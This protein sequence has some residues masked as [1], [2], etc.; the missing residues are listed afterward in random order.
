MIPRL[1]RR[2][3]GEPRVRPLP[4]VKVGKLADQVIQMARAQ[5]HEAVQ[6]LALE[7][8]DEPLREGVQVGAPRRQPHRRNSRPPR[9]P[10][11]V[12]SAR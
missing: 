7:G 1:D 3:E 11:L 8:E 12:I 4:V 10:N 5:H 9:M 6:A 2:P